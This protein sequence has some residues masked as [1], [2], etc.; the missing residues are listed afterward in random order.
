[1]LSHLADYEA[2]LGQ[3]AEAED[4]DDIRARTVELRKAVARLN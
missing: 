3:A 4:V 2:Y 1:M